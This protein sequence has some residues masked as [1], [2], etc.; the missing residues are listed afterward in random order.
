MSDNLAFQ[1]DRLSDAKQL[2]VTASTKNRPANRRKY[3]LESVGS[4]QAFL[5]TNPMLARWE[6]AVV[7]NNL[8]NSIHA[9]LEDGEVIPAEDVDEYRDALEDFS[10]RY[11]DYVIE[12]DDLEQD[13]AT[14]RVIETQN[15]TKHINET[16]KNTAPNLGLKALAIV[17]GDLAE[18]RDDLSENDERMESASLDKLKRRS[19]DKAID[20]E[21]YVRLVHQLDNIGPYL[22]KMRLKL[23]RG[24][25]ERFVVL[26][27][28]ILVVGNIK[29][30]PS[31]R[32]QNYVA[33]HGVEMGGYWVLKDQILL[34]VTTDPRKVIKNPKFRQSVVNRLTDI[35]E[36][37]LEKRI[38]K[39][40]MS[41]RQ[42]HLERVSMSKKLADEVDEEIQ[43]LSR[44]INLGGL[45]KLISKQLGY[46]VVTMEGTTRIKGSPYVYYWLVSTDMTQNV[47]NGLY[48]EVTN[49]AL[50]Y[51]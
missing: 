2:L 48:S 41:E 10:G 9:G 29:Y 36:A 46:E 33:K 4:V 32:A 21:E 38:A 37:D 1:Q 26:R 19:G 13:E 25:D 17:A 45:V 24:Y 31:A 39:H 12:Q 11:Q 50:P 51:E 28:P 5:A 15:K 43:N 16:L 14:S 44:P 30:K 42:I 6:S 49:W 27:Q 7:L 8:A 34:G 40:K 47:L 20:D 35:F 23:P 18:L 3:L 22:D